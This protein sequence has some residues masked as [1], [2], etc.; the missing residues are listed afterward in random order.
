LSFAGA[1]RFLYNDLPSFESA[2]KSGFKPGLERIEFLCRELGNPH[3]KFK[4]IHVAGTNGKGSVCAMLA[5]VFSA[6]GYKTGLYTSPHLLSFTERIRVNGVPVSEEDVSKFVTENLSRIKASGATFFE[7][8]TALAFDHFARESVEIAV[9]ETGLGGRLDAT[10]V[11]DPLLAVIT[12][13]SLDHTDILG[14]SVNLLAAEK[15]GIIKPGRPIVSTRHQ[16]E[17]RDVIKGFADR[18]NSPFY[19]SGQNVSVTNV[20]HQ[21][22]TFRAIV[23]FKNPVSQFDVRVPLGGEIQVENLGLCLEVFALSGQM[24]FRFEPSGIADGLL[25][26]RDLTGFRGRMEILQRN[27]LVVCDAAHNESGIVHLFQH[28]AKHRIPDQI[29]FGMTKDRDLLEF[30]PH[31]PES[32]TYH[33]VSAKS[34]RAADARML[35]EIARVQGRKADDYSSVREGVDAAM[36]AAGPGGMVLIAGSIY[37]L[38][39]AMEMGWDGVPGG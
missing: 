6:H 35:S 29:V 37:M 26:L 32:A 13:I 8:T 3:R 1:V 38:G 2:G 25:L 20:S 18:M 11:I 23:G 5:A 14:K 22:D 7:V 17:I 36:K 34:L 28:L 19:E 33:F 12:S 39:E 30:L 10:N 27:P 15:A 21:L 4:T 31:M 24:G 16:A 9:I